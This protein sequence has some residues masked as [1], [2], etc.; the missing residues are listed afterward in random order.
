MAMPA[1]T[2][3]AAAGVAAVLKAGDGKGAM[4]EEWARG[5]VDET[6]N[7]IARAMRKLL[8]M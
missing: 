7:E 8:G 1:A 6:T 4:V 5:N 2:P 3:A